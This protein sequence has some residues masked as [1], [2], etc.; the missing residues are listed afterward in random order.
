MQYLQDFALLQA[1]EILC[2][3]QG[4]MIMDDAWMMFASFNSGMT[5]MLSV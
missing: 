3:C 2:L 1:V 4:I 5:R